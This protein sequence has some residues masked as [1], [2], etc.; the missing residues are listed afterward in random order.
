MHYSGEMVCYIV[1]E[2]AWGVIECS[3]R[4]GRINELLE[5]SRYTSKTKTVVLKVHVY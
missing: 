4:I 1:G 2:E 3:R 5:V